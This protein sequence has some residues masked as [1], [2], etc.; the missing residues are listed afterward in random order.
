[1]DA[2]EGWSDE[3]S[4]LG[5]LGVKWAVAGNRDVELDPSGTTD[6]FSWWTVFWSMNDTSGF[7]EKVEDIYGVPFSLTTGVSRGVFRITISFD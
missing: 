2:N 5:A 7:C 4:V 6:W 3:V 1:M